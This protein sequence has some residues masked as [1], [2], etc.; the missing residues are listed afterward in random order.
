MMMRNDWNPKASSVLKFYNH[1]IDRMAQLR[2]AKNTQGAGVVYK[3]DFDGVID[4]FRYYWRKLMS[5]GKK[6]KTTPD[7]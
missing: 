3:E 1:T 2:T 4:M 5:I 7:P 6:K